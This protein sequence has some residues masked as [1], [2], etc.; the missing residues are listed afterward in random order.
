MVE[1]STGTD[2][3]DT[4]KNVLYNLDVAPIILH[5]P[6]KPVVEYEERPDDYTDELDSDENKNVTK[7]EDEPVPIG[8][9]NDSVDEVVDAILG[10]TAS[11]TAD[12]S[13][14][15]DAL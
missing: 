15:G 5:V 14:G 1:L 12:N 13:T 2:D 3:L 4:I 6:E 9:G 8:S 11:E 10:E 7:Y